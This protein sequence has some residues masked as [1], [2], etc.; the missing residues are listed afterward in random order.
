MFK[1]VRDGE[2]ALLIDKRGQSMVVDGPQRVSVFR[3]SFQRL[4]RVSADQYQYIQFQKADGEVEHMQGPCSMFINP[5]VVESAVVKQA[6]SLSANEVLV[7]YKRDRGDRIVQRRIQYGPTIFT[8]S[9]DE[10]LHEFVWHGTD[11]NN[12]TKKIPGGLRFTNLRVIPDQFYYNTADVRTKDDALISVKLMLFFELK[13]IER[14]LNQ[15]TDPIGDFINAV[16]ADVITFASQMNYDEF[17]DSSSQLNEL[18]NYPQLMGRSGTI[19]YEVTKVVFRGYHAGDKLQGL[20]D[21][22]IEKRAQL[23]VRMEEEQQKQD[24]TDSKLC[25]Q[26]QT[27]VLQQELLKEQK[28]HQ[29]SM[30]KQQL[31]HQMELDTKKHRE[32]IEREKDQRMAELEAQRQRQEEETAH[33]RELKKLGVD[34]TELL[35]AQHPKPDQVVRV[36]TPGTGGGNIHIHP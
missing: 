27:S 36:I 3:K 10:W 9:A 14:M 31:T 18:K 32:R 1:T 29:Y 16:Q 33:L 13:D 22:S 17:I 21:H 34:L 11:R 20:H 8:P 28:V 30:E 5:L 25:N 24:L 26:Q 7:V 6:H 15:T 2:R 4:Q 12:K 23:K 19:G 35:V